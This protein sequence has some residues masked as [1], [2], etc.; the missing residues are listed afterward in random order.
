MFQRERV[1]IQNP[2]SWRIGKLT[3]LLTLLLFLA[4]VSPRMA[5]QVNE[6]TW[7]SG[8]NT[9]NQ[10]GVYGTKGV[11]AAGNV[12]GARSA[13]VT[14]TDAG[15]NLWL[16][17]GFGYAASGTYS[18]L[19]DLWKY[20]PSTGE[21]TWMSGSNTLNQPGVYGTK[22]VP[23][24]GNVPG[25]RFQSVTWTDASGNL[26]LFGGYG[27]DANGLQGRLNDLWKYTPASGEW[28]WM[29]GSN[30]VKQPGVYG[31]L[32]VPAAGNVPGARLQAVSWT[33]SSGNLWLFGGNGYDGLGAGGRLN[34]LWKYTPSTGE[35]TWVSGSN[36]A[37]QPGVY[38]TLGVPAAGNVPGARLQA[39]SWTDSSGNLWLFGGAGS[40][41][42]NGNN[43]L[44]NDLWKYTPSTGEWTWVSGSN[45]A[46]QPGVYGTKGMPAAGNVPGARELAISWTDSSGNLWLFGGDVYDYLND[47]WKY[48]P[49]TGEW[50]WMS[51]S[52]T[53]NQPGVYGT[54]G[55][56]AS[57]DVPGGRIRAVS[58]TDSSGNLWLFG[59]NGDDGVG[60]AGN[61]NDLWKYG[62]ST[63]LA[64]F[65]TTPAPG[66]TLSGSKVTF[67][68]DPGVGATRFVL[69]LGTTFKGS[70]D[71]FSGAATT[72]TTAQ[73]SAIPTNGAYLYARLWYYVNGKWQFVDALY[74]E[75]GTPTPPAFTTPAPGSTL[76]GS[77]VTFRWNPGDVA[78][79]FVL[80]LGTTGLGSSDVYSGAATKGTSVQLTTV[81]TNGA[82]LYARLWYYLNETWKYVD[83]TYTEASQ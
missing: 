46:N 67:G 7:M 39:V 6:W 83:A 72:G 55:V 29:S 37:N 1:T 26:W 25:A 61:L 75:A 52:N 8:S 12:P 30:T 74:T 3:S 76:P 63:V 15:G 5:A 34:D 22:G 31:T 36:T 4:G 78:T 43:N 19:N 69:R 49:S 23:A 16:F 13:A 44:L 32:G 54:K 14:W 66:S 64:P 70:T 9:V 62:P 60:A 73:V 71:V 17:G 20:T 77:T 2:S 42:V 21:W 48:T 41:Q 53:V 28:M 68:W 50:T 47:L 57:I 79:R 59:G 24:A 81:P 80:R 38:G 58:W 35:W 33:D 10:L 51:G 11:P 82:K 56:P 45:T 40:Q 18:Y 27:I 65:L